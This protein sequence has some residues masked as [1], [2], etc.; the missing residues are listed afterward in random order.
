M[1]FCVHIGYGWYVSV[2]DGYYCVDFRRLYVPYGVP[3]KHVYPTRD[4]ISLHLDEWAQLLELAPTIH[5]RHP[6]LVDVQRQV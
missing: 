2:T 3:R 6:E 1:A 4:G 5:E